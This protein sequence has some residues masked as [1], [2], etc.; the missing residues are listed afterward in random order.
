M[1]Q[2]F[3][4]NSFNRIRNDI[5]SGRGNTISA[6]R[7]IGQLVRSGSLSKENAI[8]LFERL[9]P[10]FK[11]NPFKQKVLNDAELAEVRADLKARRQLDIGKLSSAINQGGVSNFEADEYAKDIRKSQGRTERTFDPSD[12]QQTLARIEGSRPERSISYAERNQLGSYSPNYIES[13]RLRDSAREQFANTPQAVKDLQREFLRNGV[14]E[15]FRAKL[16][17]FNKD[18]YAERFGDQTGT[19]KAQQTSP[20]NRQDFNNTIDALKE[21]KASTA[22]TRDAFNKELSRAT[23]PS[24]KVVNRAETVPKATRNNVTKPTGNQSFEERQAAIANDPFLSK[25]EKKDLQFNLAADEYGPKFDRK[26]FNFLLDRL[27][28]SKIRQNRDS[29]AQERQNIYTQGLAS[30]FANF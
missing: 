6:Q 21:S 8:Q 3:L 4:D 7:E 27:T 5:E 12:Y 18:R 25:K 24:S 14:T 20:F 1:T 30:M 9:Q 19:E 26:Q 22:S 15:S 2:S 10:T 29:Q 11:A 13:K 17:Q 16:L 28:G 23:G